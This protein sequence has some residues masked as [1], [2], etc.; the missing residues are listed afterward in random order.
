MKLG[1]LRH[2]VT[3]EKNEPVQD[4]QTGEM[5]SAW[6]RFARVYASIEPLS[7]RE[8]VEAKAVQ[9]EYTARIQIRYRAGVL[10]TMRVLH[11]ETIYSIM[12]PPLSDKDSGIEYLTLMVAA[13]VNDG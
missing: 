8:F 3:I 7:T 11:G 5:T 9:G 13:G 12:G 10:A 4:Q 6:V 2:L 1:K